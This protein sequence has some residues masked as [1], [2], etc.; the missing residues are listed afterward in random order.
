MSDRYEDLNTNWQTLSRR[1][2]IGQG[3]LDH[4]PAVAAA[5]RQYLDTGD[6][7]GARCGGAGNTFEIHGH[8]RR[9][10]FNAI[11]ERVRRGGHGFH[12]V[13]QGH[14]PPNTGFTEYH[15]FNLVNIHGT[16]HL[17]DAFTFVHTSN[18]EEMRA[19]LTYN[20][21]NRFWF[22]TDFSARMV[23]LA[24]VGR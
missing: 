19:Y 8:L 11:L 7:V 14:R 22:S 17:F 12:V 15:F 2:N 20:H 1:L 16:V 18:R 10:A 5:V 9:L 3:C 4:C 13:V 24:A 21:L 6:I 23:E